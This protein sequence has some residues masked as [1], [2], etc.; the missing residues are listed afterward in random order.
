[1]PVLLV[2][3]E[4]IKMPNFDAASLWKFLENDN[5]AISVKC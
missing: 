1:M 2:A 5:T 3:A 4:D